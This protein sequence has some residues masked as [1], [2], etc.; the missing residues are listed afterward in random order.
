MNTEYRLFYY[1][2]ISCISSEI[3]LITGHIICLPETA[4]G[5]PRNICFTLLPSDY[6]RDEEY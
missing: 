1:S 2:L 4:W 6:A 5:A 3:Y